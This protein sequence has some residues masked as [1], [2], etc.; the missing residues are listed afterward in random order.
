[1]SDFPLQNS[2]A[3]GL[4]RSRPHRANAFEGRPSKQTST[5]SLTPPP[6]Y[7]RRD[8]PSC[9]NRMV[10]G[11]SHSATTTPFGLDGRSRDFKG[12][13]TVPRVGAIFPVELPPSRVFGG[14][15]P[16]PTGG[17]LERHFSGSEAGDIEAISISI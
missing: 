13:R 1:M 10:R 8:R 16:I 9:P 17:G 5:E 12:S 6:L 4:T 3:Y 11:G 14:A 2:N 7:R 15:R